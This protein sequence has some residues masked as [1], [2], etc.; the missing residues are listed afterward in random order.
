[1][2]DAFDGRESSLNNSGA[3]HRSVP[4]QVCGVIVALSERLRST[5]VSPK[6]AMRAEKPL[7]IKMLLFVLLAGI[8]R[9]RNSTYAF[10]I[11]VDRR[12]PM[13]V[14]QSASS[15]CQLRE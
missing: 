11:C 6:S 4:T 9:W 2:S 8:E 13:E 5:V 14:F 7:S 1:M 10:Q 15:I 3:I 12:P